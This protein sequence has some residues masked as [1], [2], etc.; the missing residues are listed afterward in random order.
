MGFYCHFIEENLLW[1]KHDLRSDLFC[2]RANQPNQ[3]SVKVV[4]KVPFFSHK[5][6]DLGNTEIPLEDLK[7]NKRE[8]SQV[9]YF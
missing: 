5:G 4:S 9:P 7:I 1:V 8:D 3:L 2:H 6:D